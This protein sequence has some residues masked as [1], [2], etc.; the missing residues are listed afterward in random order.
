MEYEDAEELLYSTKWKTSCCSQGEECWCRIIEPVEKI[1]YD[2][3]GE[4][5]IAGSGSIPKRAAEHIVKLHNDNLDSTKRITELEAELAKKDKE[6]YGDG[7]IAG[8]IETVDF[9][10]GKA[11]NL[12]AEN[13][14]LREILKEYMDSDY[15]GSEF[16]VVTDANERYNRAKAALGD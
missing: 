1:V 8:C 6:L 9:W 7:T 13:R 3:T 4:I 2:E 10:K 15:V 14:R 5:Y 12:E 16:F 11:I